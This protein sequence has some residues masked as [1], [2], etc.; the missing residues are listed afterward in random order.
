MK[1]HHASR[2]RQSL[3]L[4]PMESRR[5][6]SGVVTCT[7]TAGSLLIKGDGGDNSI[8]VAGGPG[9]LTV[10]GV[11]PTFVTFPNTFP[12]G[13]TLTTTGTSANEEFVFIDTTITATVNITTGGGT[14]F[15]FVDSSTVL[16]SMAIATGDAADSVNLAQLTGPV[17][18]TGNLTID[19]GKGNDSI[20]MGNDASGF[21]VSVGSN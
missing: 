20:N 19:S 15:V 16:G 8:D 18:I 2:T 9:T 4:E 12:A 11:G 21:F 7:L 14:D 5:L 6:L 1:R 17:F 13:V 3:A 10:T